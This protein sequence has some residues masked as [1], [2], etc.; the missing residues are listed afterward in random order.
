MADTDETNSTIIYSGTKVSHLSAYPNSTLSPDD[1]FLISK[2]DDDGKAKHLVI[3]AD[4][5]EDFLKMMNKLLPLDNVAQAKLKI[6]DGSSPVRSIGL[7]IMRMD[8]ERPLFS[9]GIS[10]EIAGRKSKK[11]VN[12]T[13]FIAACRTLEELREYVK[14]DAFSVQID[15]NI[16][17]QVEDSFSGQ[18]NNL[19]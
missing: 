12:S 4:N 18:V 6:S 16:S 17:K 10:I 9:L 19:W 14:S 1:L 8:P 2:K 11:A 7:L 13:I 3:N 15:K 5:I